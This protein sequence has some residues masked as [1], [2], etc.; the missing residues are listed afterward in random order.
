[1][2]QGQLAE[3]S[4]HRFKKYNAVMRMTEQELEDDSLNKY[5]T[6]IHVIQS[7]LRKLSR[8][9]QPPKNSKVYRGLSRC[10]L[11]EE[12][13]VPD[14][15]G[16]KGGVEYGFLSTSADIEVALTYAGIQKNRPNP[17][18]FELDIGKTSMGADVS[19]LSQFPHEK[20]ACPCRPFVKG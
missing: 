3:I 12:F 15:Q 20:G 8:V 7:L 16:C 1:M 10:K 19:F 6:T 14:E 9:S 2:H 13:F 11:P 18:I 17:I 5:P 4:I